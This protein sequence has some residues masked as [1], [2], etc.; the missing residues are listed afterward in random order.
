MSPA[1]QAKARSVIGIAQDQSGLGSAIRQAN[2][3]QALNERILPRLPESLR[4][5][6]RVAC[7]EQGVLMLAAESSAWLTQA[8]LYSDSILEAARDLWPQAIHRVELFVATEA[9][10]IAREWSTRG[11]PDR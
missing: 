11:Q 5:H 3:F 2:A 7:I 10:L 9:F 4:L 8:R 1:R 6:V